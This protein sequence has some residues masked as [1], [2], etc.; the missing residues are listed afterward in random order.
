MVI[1]DEVDLTVSSCFAQKCFILH[2][3]ASF[4]I[5]L[6]KDSVFGGMVCTFNIFLAES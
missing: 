4:F 5:N 6:Q 3:T 1:S 2:L